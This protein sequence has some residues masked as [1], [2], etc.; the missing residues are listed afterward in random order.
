MKAKQLVDDIE[1]IRA[2]LYPPFMFA[3]ETQTALG[4]NIAQTLFFNGTWLI[5]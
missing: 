3:T 5:I 2:Q 4:L 1:Q